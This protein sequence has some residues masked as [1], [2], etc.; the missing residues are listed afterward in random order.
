MN[1]LLCLSCGNNIQLPQH[2]LQLFLVPTNKVLRNFNLKKEWDFETLK[3]FYRVFQPGVSRLRKASINYHDF[4]EALLEVE[5]VSY[6][7]GIWLAENNLKSVGNA[8]IEQLKKAHGSKV[9]SVF[10]PAEVGFVCT[11]MYF[12]YTETSNVDNNENRKAS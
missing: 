4:R 11:Y 9:P 10:L 8:I 7:N 5:R 1:T 6:T 2:I 12:E 3:S